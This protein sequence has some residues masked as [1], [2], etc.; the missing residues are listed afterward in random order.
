MS[1]LPWFRFYNEA[2]SDEKI[3]LAAKILGVSK[4]ETLG[5]WITLL[6]LAAKSP[7][8][9]CLLISQKI[10][11]LTEDLSEIMDCEYDKM[12]EIIN[13]FL[14]LDML[15]IRE[16]RYWIKN[17]NKRQYTKTE[18]EKSAHAQYV[19]E[20]RDEKKLSQCDNHNGIT[21]LSHSVSV[22]ESESLIKDLNAKTNSKFFTTNDASKAYCQ[23]TGL[24]SIPSSVYPR[25]ENIL[26]LLQH[27]G[28]D[29]TIDRLT[30]AKNSWISQ[31][32]KT[33]GASYKLTNPAWIDYAITGETLGAPPQLSRAE[34]E[35]KELEELIRKG[36]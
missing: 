36:Q 21:N 32:N 6:S 4:Q 3:I 13:M 26:D 27:Y 30:K 11:Y 29:E 7:E 8:R 2:V 34:R 28:W 16:G 5:F 35:Q 19:K 1:E 18:E 24:V 14:S 9:G 23:V 12:D 33:N 31:K 10:G 17:W 22:N 25:L 20:W 15:E